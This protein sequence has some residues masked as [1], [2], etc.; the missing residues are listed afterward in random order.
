MLSNQMDS[1]KAAEMLDTYLRLSS[2]PVGVKL[3]KDGSLPERVRRPQETLGHPLAV[4]QGAAMA[5]NLGWAVG[6]LREDHGCPPSLVILGQEKEASEGDMAEMVF[7]LYGETREAC[8]RTQEHV[9]YF[10][11]R[12]YR[13]MALAPLAR[14]LFEPDLVLVYGNPA[15]VA[16]LVQS[17]LYRSGGAITSTFT[18]RNSC[19]GEFVAPILTGECQV[20]LPGSGERVF[21]LAQDH[22]MCFAIPHGRLDD[23]LNGLE[24]THRLGTMRYPTPFQGFRSKPAFPEK[25]EQY[26]RA[27]RL[28]EPEED[29]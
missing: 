17:A 25:Y 9:P 18:G 3:Y 6:F 24:A 29:R 14:G 10:P 11:Y 5:R 13:S 2:F 12:E 15:Q 7:P 4:C 1:Q 21:A 28:G 20:I 27:L 16:R 22:E 23:V 8:S 19:A 26:T